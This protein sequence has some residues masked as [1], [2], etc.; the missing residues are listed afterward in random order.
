MQHEISKLP[1]LFIATHN[2]PHQNV[3][4]CAAVL[5]LVLCLANVRSTD[6]LTHEIP[7]RGGSSC[8]LTASALGEGSD[9]DKYRLL[10]D[11]LRSIKHGKHI[12][13][14]GVKANP[15]RGEGKSHPVQ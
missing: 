8:L 15:Q 4:Q 2:E 10:I 11:I 7:N 1:R 13:L 12:S 9:K 3:K 6:A 5:F 14:H